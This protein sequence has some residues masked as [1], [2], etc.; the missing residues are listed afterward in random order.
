MHDNK[1]NNNYLFWSIIQ[2]AIYKAGSV[3]IFEGPHMFGQFS[4]LLFKYQ[5]VSILFLTISGYSKV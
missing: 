2:K 3:G 5:V 4:F 1:N